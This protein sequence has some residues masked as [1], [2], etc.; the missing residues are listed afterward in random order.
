MP[1]LPL[2]HSENILPIIHVA[3]PNSWFKDSYLLRVS[4]SIYAMKMFSLNVCDGNCCLCAHRGSV[5]LQVE[6]SIELE[7]IFFEDKPK[8]FSQVMCRIGG[9][10][11]RKFHTL[12]KLFQYPSFCDIHCICKKTC[13]VHRNKKCSVF[14]LSLFNKIYKVSGIFGYFPESLKK[15]N[16]LFFLKK[17]QIMSVHVGCRLIFFLTRDQA[18]FPFRFVNNIPAGMTKRKESLIHSAAHWYKLNE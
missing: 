9:L 1:G 17:I 16:M 10:L 3:F 4:V 2:S 11:C 18:L 15:Y 14:N 8:H 6:L 13:D 7:R 12:C 5:G